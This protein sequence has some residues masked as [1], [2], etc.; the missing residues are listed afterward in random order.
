MRAVCVCALLAA[1]AGA[2]AGQEFEAVVVKPSHSLSNG[3]SSR[4]DRSQWTATNESLKNLIMR[5]YGVRDY[6]VEGP[7]WLASTRFDIAAKYPA[8]MPKDGDRYLAAQQAMMRKML[9]DSFKL[10]VHRDSKVFPVYGLVVVKRGIKFK[11]AA[12]TGSDIQNSD[13]GHF[14]GT[15]VSMSAF[16]AFL[17]RR[18]DQPVL[19]MTG[20]KGCYD[21][22][23]DWVP[24]PRQRAGGAGDTPIE[25]DLQKGPTLE[26]A[27]QEQLGLKLEAR[28]APIEILVVDHAE[29][30]P[31]EN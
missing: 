23:M 29:R 4:G 24:Q 10:A 11:P 19:D 27:I 21:L 14:T 20:L 18:E 16:A 9:R 12:D 2:A 13:N 26:D 28:K 25:T 15:C 5:A 7:D 8:G 6:Q 17:A 30:V 1:L 31:L 22:T 3:S